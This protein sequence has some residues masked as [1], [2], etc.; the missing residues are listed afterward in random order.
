MLPPHQFPGAV[1]QGG[2]GG[3]GVTEVRVTKQLHPRDEEGAALGWWEVG[4]VT[5][6]VGEAGGEH[7]L[8]REGGRE[9][10]MVR[11]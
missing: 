10:G 8:R 1:Q 11:E 3:L 9:G 2:E 4:E 5:R 7:Q 6:G